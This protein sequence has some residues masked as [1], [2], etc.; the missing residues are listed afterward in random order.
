MLG[1]AIHKHA[2]AAVSV[3]VHDGAIEAP[4]VYCR[5]RAD[6]PASSEPHDHVWGAGHNVS[7]DYGEPKAWLCVDGAR[8]ELSPVSACGHS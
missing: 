8:M 7:A 5:A 1:K 6:S 2:L 4:R 3:L